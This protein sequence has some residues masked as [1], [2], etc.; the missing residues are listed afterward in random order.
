MKEKS[1]G[2]GSRRQIDASLLGLRHIDLLLPCRKAESL[3]T[4][5]F[6]EATCVACFGGS[7]EKK[8]NPLTNCGKG[9]LSGQHPFCIAGNFLQFLWRETGETQS[10]YYTPET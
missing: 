10:S 5:L 2:L 9:T 8:K 3:S 6:S 4:L 1:L 7:Q